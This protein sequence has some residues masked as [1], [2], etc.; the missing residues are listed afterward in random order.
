MFPHS[1]IV[2]VYRQVMNGSN[3]SEIMH[4]SN[5]SQVSSLFGWFI[6]LFNND[7][8]S[9][10]VDHMKCIHWVSY[11]FLW[12]LLVTPNCCRI[13]SAIFI[14]NDY[15]SFFFFF[16]GS[17]VTHILLYTKVFLCSTIPPVSFP[18]NPLPFFEFP[19]PTSILS[20]SKICLFFFFFSIL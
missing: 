11:R 17:N 8:L 9:G 6:G 15:S 14:S 10:Y 16:K 19:L 13:T 2:L 20:C 5:A 18:L 4:L 7:S 1:E 12:Q 3:C